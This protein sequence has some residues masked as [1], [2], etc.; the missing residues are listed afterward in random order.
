[1][2]GRFLSST[3]RLGLYRTKQ[4]VRAGSKGQEDQFSSRASH[5]ISRRV[6]AVD[7]LYMD[8]VEKWTILVDLG[9]RAPTLLEDALSG[10]PPGGEQGVKA[11]M[12]LLG[13]LLCYCPCVSRNGK[14]AAAAVSEE[15]L[16]GVSSQK[17]RGLIDGLPYCVRLQLCLS[18]LMWVRS[19]RDVQNTLAHLRMP[20]ATTR[21]FKR[22]VVADVFPTCLSEMCV[23]PF[24]TVSLMMDESLNSTAEQVPAPHAWRPDGYYED[25]EERRA[26]SFASRLGKRRSS[27]IP[28]GGGTADSGVASGQS[29]R[30]RSCVGLT[31]R[32]MVMLREIQGMRPVPSDDDVLAGR[33]GLHVG[34]LRLQAPPTNLGQ[35]YTNGLSAS[36]YALSDA[37]RGALPSPLAVDNEEDE[38]YHHN[39]HRGE[40][41]PLDESGQLE[42]TPIHI[43]VSLAADRVVVTRHCAM[44]HAAILTS[45]FV[46]GRTVQFTTNH[47]L[48]LD[49]VS[50]LFAELVEAGWVS[51]AICEESLRPYVP[52]W[53]VAESVLVLVPPKDT[54]VCRTHDVRGMAD[55]IVQCA[56]CS[57]LTEDVAQISGSRFYRDLRE[58]VQRLQATLISRGNDAS[59][60]VSWVPVSKS[61]SLYATPQKVDCGD[62]GEFQTS[63][64]E[65]LRHCHTVTFL[66]TPR[67][68]RFTPREME[69]WWWNGLPRSVLVVGVNSHPLDI[70][71]FFP[72]A[73]FLHK[74][75]GN[76]FRYRAVRRVLLRKNVH[77]GREGIVRNWLYR[78]LW[79]RGLARTGL[80]GQLA[81]KDKMRVLPGGDV[82]KGG[83]HAVD[84][85][86]W[87]RTVDYLANPGKMTWMALVAAKL[88]H[89]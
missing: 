48:L 73:P 64:N 85:L 24:T 44:A 52:L 39:I 11:E 71:Y 14:R 78:S 6:R 43:P 38:V 13:R 80:Q 7:W 42:C 84:A 35:S 89:I 2:R 51:A 22:G 87:E 12:N 60:R 86:K 1:M 8:P 49:Y 20:F 47:P 63:V 62:A 79:C 5:I 27:C 31:G 88:L 36:S 53:A 23:D 54:E 4:H 28:S 45:L 69:G 76:A 68:C 66:Y 65:V 26:W 3:F 40:G 82:T 58:E 56:P 75:V 70:V 74:K 50:F 29:R 21:R 32:D 41:C 33:S 46:E 37:Q 17:H 77:G 19:L 30:R 81:V 72:Q 61:T 67:N 15:H 18:F 59:W 55:M 10:A 83:E 16:C 9:R 57:V 25:E 34:R